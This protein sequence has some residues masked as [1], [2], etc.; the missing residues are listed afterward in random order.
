VRESLQQFMHREQEA[1]QETAQERKL[2]RAIAFLRKHLASG[3][4]K[5]KELEQAAE[6]C[7][8]SS[9]TLRRAKEEVGVLATKQ[10]PDWS[11]SL[12]QDGQDGQDGRST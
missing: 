9:R 1:A 8:I 10:G 2:A 7:G 11:S 12:S 5:T 3:P 6:E 4:V